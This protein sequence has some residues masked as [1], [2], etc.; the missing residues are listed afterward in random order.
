M[1]QQDEILGQV[2]GATILSK[3]DLK[4]WLPLDTSCQFITGLHHIYLSLGKVSIYRHALGLNNAPAFISNN[5]GYTLQLCHQYAIAYIDDVLIFSI[6]IEDH[7]EHIRQSLTVLKEAGL[8]VKPQECDWGKR[9]LQSTDAKVAVP[10]HRVT[11]IA[12][13]KQPIVNNNDSSV[14]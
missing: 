9:T 14:W 2:R 1:R 6:S 12:D 7:L 10:K 4:S 5:H 11:A 8:K 3:L 13:Y